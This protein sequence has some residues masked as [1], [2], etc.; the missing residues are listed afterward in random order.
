MLREGIVE[1][2]VE[3][4]NAMV[5]L[6]KGERNDWLRGGARNQVGFAQGVGDAAESFCGNARAPAQLG[7]MYYPRGSA[8][9]R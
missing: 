7:L 5:E 8:V 3:W 1:M 2:A 6:N 4:M 9:F